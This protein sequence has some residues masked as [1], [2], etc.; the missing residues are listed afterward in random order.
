MALITAANFKTFAG[1]GDTENDAQIALMLTLVEAEAAGY[2]N[3]LFEDGSTPRTEYFD[4]DGISDFICP[5]YYPVV[6]VTTLHD[7]VNVP[8]SYGSDTLISTDYHV[9]YPGRIELNGLKFNKGKKNIKLV[10]VGGW[11]S[12]DT[13]QEFL[14]FQKILYGALS[15]NIQRAGKE[16]DLSRAVANLNISESYIIELPPHIKR[17]LGRYRRHAFG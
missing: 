2:C 10:Y 16:A 15:W 8:P 14:V 12:D 6:S 5:K 4:G 1:I 3:H 11:A 7:D 9:R 13:T 17:P